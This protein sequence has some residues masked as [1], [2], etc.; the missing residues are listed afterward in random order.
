MAK[1]KTHEEFIEEISVKNPNIEIL[2]EYISAKEKILYKAK[3]FILWKQSRNLWLC[4]ALEWQV[5]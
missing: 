5:I 1:R 4:L 3:E 2:G